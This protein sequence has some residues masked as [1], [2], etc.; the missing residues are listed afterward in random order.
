MPF[1]LFGDE[2]DVGLQANSI[3]KTGA[4]YHGNKFPLLF[5]SF[6]EFRLPLFIYSDVPFIALFG[7]NEWGV[8][9]VSVFW[10]LMG[11]V[12][13][14]LLINRLFNQ[15]VAI[16]C[17]FILALSPW[18]L[19]YSRQGGI[20]SLTLV[21]FAT[22][23]VWAFF[24][25]LESLRWLIISAVLF[26]LTFYVYA[27]AA[28]FTPLIVTLLIILFR[29]KILLFK[30]K[31]FIPLIIGIII[32]IPYININ[33]TSKGG[34]RFSSISIWSDKKLIDDIMLKRR[35]EEESTGRLFHNRPF[36]YLYEAS[37]N[38]LKSLSLDFLFFR[39]D[40]NLRHSTGGMGEFYF[41]ELLSVTLG[42]IFLVRNKFKSK[43]SFLILGWLLIAPIPSS[44]TKDGGNHASRLILMLI[45]LAIL[46]SLGF[47][48]ILSNLRSRK[49][50]L[51]VF[52]IFTIAILN[53]TNY[54]HRYYKD[55]MRDGWRFWQTG[56]REALTY[57]K[58]NESKYSRI[59]MNNSYETIL[60]RFLFWNNSDPRKFL[61][62]YKGEEEVENLVNGFNGFKYGDKYYFGMINGGVNGVVK[63]IKNNELYMV[64]YRDET[65]LIDWRVKTP[66]ELELLKT[67]VNPLGEP[68]FFIVTKK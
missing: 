37:G 26:S 36:I 25:G 59:Y 2:I 60:P 13:A 42:F 32:L 41:I 22:F 67:I 47:A 58:D 63:V 1:E 29:A 4:D 23:G 19:Q 54:F 61:G 39:G 62:Q 48:E 46:S 34:E 11:I 55:W 40:P 10:G 52:I 68:V 66:S 12:G 45:P 14:Y 9:M 30:T 21:T 8:R 56:Y 17:G 16:I 51:L 50:Q 65:G 6:S 64:S 20:E 7:L 3:L 43:N 15:K 49:R 24:K 57:I 35:Y 44:L 5:R 33:L 31:L 53:I 18:H 27:T 38:Y 28:V